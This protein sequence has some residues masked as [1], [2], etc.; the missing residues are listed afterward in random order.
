MTIN[1][2]SV[3]TDADLQNEV[4]GASWLASAMPQGAVSFVAARSRSL[5]D[6]LD[7]LKSRTP[8][9]RA[10]D[11]V[12]VTELRRAVVYRA[13]QRICRNASTGEG[14]VWHVRA[15]DFGREYEGELARLR[16]TVGGNLTG[17]P[18]GFTISRR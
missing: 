7:H 1:V 8:P 16:P 5:E 10:A 14:D 3:A 11:L 13:L 18:I 4:A 17:T 12:D 9:I 2:E 15:R 6:V